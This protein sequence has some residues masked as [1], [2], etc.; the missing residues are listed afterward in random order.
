[1]DQENSWKEYSQIPP[2]HFYSGLKAANRT[3]AMISVKELQIVH[4]THVIR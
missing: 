4:W 1:M 3:R 2:D